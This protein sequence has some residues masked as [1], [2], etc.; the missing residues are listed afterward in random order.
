M[1]GGGLHTYTDRVGSREGKRG[2]KD[3]GKEEGRGGILGYIGAIGR[4]I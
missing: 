3:K 4:Y 2:G 1:K